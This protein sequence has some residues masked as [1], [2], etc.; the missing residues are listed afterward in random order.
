M[1]GLLLLLLLT[2][3]KS[4]AQAHSG[5]EFEGGEAVETSI[6]P[7]GRGGKQGFVAGGRCVVFAGLR[8]LRRLKGTFIEAQPHK[9]CEQ[10]ASGRL[11]KEE[12]FR[13]H[14]LFRVC[15]HTERVGAMPKTSSC[16]ARTLWNAHHIPTEPHMLASMI[17]VPH[18]CDDEAIVGL[19]R[20]LNAGRVP[21]PYPNAACL[22]LCHMPV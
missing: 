12:P 13:L 8:L 7:T 2:P 19:P 14:G 21:R 16:L 5:C 9:R 15:I 3:Q 10:E 1:S 18:V 11:V 4:S 22:V 17:L 20:P 6:R